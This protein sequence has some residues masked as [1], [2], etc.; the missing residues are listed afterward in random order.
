MQV[1]IAVKTVID[2]L[3]AYDVLKPVRF[4]LFNDDI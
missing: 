3:S 4:V 2:H 1:E